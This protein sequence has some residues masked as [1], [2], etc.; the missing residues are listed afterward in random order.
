MAAV[1]HPTIFETWI[2]HVFS[3]VLVFILPIVD[4]QFKHQIIT[5]H[6]PVCDAFS[7]SHVRLGVAFGS[8]GDFAAVTAYMTRAS[9]RT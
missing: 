8:V 4:V 2:Q 9:F 1:S 7:E 6:F 3:M 5:V